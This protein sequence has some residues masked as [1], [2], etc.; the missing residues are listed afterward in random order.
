M[1]LTQKQW[2]R[3]APLLPSQ[4]GTGRRR[5]NNREVLDGILW[6]LKTGAPWK[7]LPKRY[8][9]YQT[10]HRRLQTWSKEDAL[11]SV[12]EQLARDLY[13]QGDIDLSLY[14]GDKTGASV[15]RGGIAVTMPSGERTPRLWPSR[16]LVV[17]RSPLVYELLKLTRASLSKAL[18]QEGVSPFDLELCIGG[19]I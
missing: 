6:I 18:L 15:Q 16:M 8:P 1:D 17:F 9:P 4:Q 10:C 14:F 2:E 12:L 13:E 7:D 3:L 5:R 11:P 19:K